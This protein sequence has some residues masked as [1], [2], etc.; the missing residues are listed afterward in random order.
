MPI[1]SKRFLMVLVDSSAARMP[2]PGFTM[3][4]AT[5]F[6]SERFMGS[7][8]AFGLFYP[9]RLDP[10]QGLSFQPSQKGT[11]RRRNI[12]E[13]VHNRGRVQGRDGVAAARHCN[14][15]TRPRQLRLRF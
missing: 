10:G 15:L 5:S 7:S 11:A 6:N 13:T 3:A 12:S 8:F 2:L 4:S 14:E 9:Q 1:A